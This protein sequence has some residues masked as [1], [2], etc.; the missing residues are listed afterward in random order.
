MSC[1]LSEYCHECQERHIQRK[2]YLTDKQ[3]KPRT[4]EWPVECKGI[5]KELFDSV[6]YN[7]ETGEVEVGLYDISDD[8]DMDEYAS[9]S[10][11]DKLLIQYSNNKLLFAKDV[12]GWSPYNPNRNFFQ[13]YQKEFLLCSAKRKVGRFGRRLGKSEIL[14]ISAIHFIMTT[15]EKAG[16]VIIF[17]PFDTLA[18]ELHNRILSL[19]QSPDSKADQSKISS[20]KKPFYQVC[21]HRDDINSDV[22][23]RIFTTGAK[24]G[25]GATQARG[26]KAHFI[27]IDEE[28]YLHPDDYSAIVP[29]IEE[30]PFVE[31]W[32]FSTPNAIPNAFK[33][34][35]NDDTSFK[36]FHYPYDVLRQ[37]YGDDVFEEKKNGYIRMLGYAKYRLEFEAEFFE[38]DNKIFKEKFI[39]ASGHEYNYSKYRNP[40]SNYFIGVDWNAWLNG[41]NI[42]VLERGSE[43]GEDY[44]RVAYK[45]ILDG[46][47][48]KG[49]SQQLQVTAV[50]ELL[51]LV[52]IFQADGL[53]VDEGYG[54]MQAEVLT[55]ALAQMN[56]SEILDIIN[57]SGITEIDNPIIPNETYKQK[58][59]PLLVHLMQQRL[60]SGL[61]RYS[62]LEEGNL[63]EAE[64]NKKGL[65]YQFNVY[66]VDKYDI[67]GHPIFKSPMDHFLDATMLANYSF[68]KKFEN[69]FVIQSVMA[70]TARSASKYENIQQYL[71]DLLQNPLGKTAERDVTTKIKRD[72]TFGG[73]SVVK[74]VGSNPFGK[75]KMKR[76]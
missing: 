3:G 56:K 36:D 33:N 40:N 53:A 63:R 44:L 32:G 17:V 4:E 64:A 28:G 57:F 42:C 65:P 14:C 52:E 16:T 9:L 43:K 21:Y 24:S 70:M 5:Q 15:L 55:A 67:N 71:N 8:I 41:V 22:Y 18:L 39:L 58:N 46:D 37:V 1:E 45:N 66:Q 74:K 47:T 2:G 31:L 6:F 54:S 69:I 7:E 50:K 49:S 23:I 51:D 27:L 13:Y 60:E 29:L 10:D 48:F 61:F 62:V 35:C 25:G 12:L 26:Q 30:N 73:E 68:A 19:M 34:K 38:E 75:H 11:Q 59:K 20:F 76:L 72:T